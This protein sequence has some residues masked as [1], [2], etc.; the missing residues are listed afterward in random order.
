MA[1]PCKMCD[2]HLLGEHV[3]I[4]MFIGSLKKKISI[5]GYIE[6]D[7]LEPKS[8]YLRHNEIVL[9]MKK[10]GFNH[11]SPLPKINLSSC[12]SKDHLNHKINKKRSYSILLKRCKRC[13]KLK[14]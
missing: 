5:N 2:K 9:E 11:R 7:L 4:H 6:N 13:R 10:R 12:L 3:E 8:I 14:S 1:P